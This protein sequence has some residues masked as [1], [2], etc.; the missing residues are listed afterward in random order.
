M[1]MFCVKQTSVIN[2]IYSR[3]Q[4]FSYTRVEHLEGRGKASVLP[5]NIKLGC[6][7]FTGKFERYGMY[8]ISPLKHWTWL[9]L[10]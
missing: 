1:F 2:L 10:G 7:D 4:L 3:Q 5:E 6:K 8:T 9:W